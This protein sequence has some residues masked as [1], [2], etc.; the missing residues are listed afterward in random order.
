MTNRINNCDLQ[1]IHKSTSN[2]FD[3][4]M[5]GQHFRDLR[6]MLMN[7]KLEKQIDNLNLYLKQINPY[8]VS[9]N[10]LNTTRC[11]EDL[12]NLGTFCVYNIRRIDLRVYGYYFIAIYRENSKLLSELI[13][14]RSTVAGVTASG[15]F[16]PRLSTLDASVYKIFQ[17]HD[18]TSI[19]A[20]LCFY[21]PFEFIYTSSSTILLAAIDPSFSQAVKLNFD[22]TLRLYRV[23]PGVST[24]TTSFS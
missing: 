21:T 9:G 11:F 17:F 23:S 3:K 20:S 7:G 15:N 24:G 1:V 10:D 22:L 16:T 18:K 5:Q 14:Y 2:Y 6:K 13:S 19:G 4:A 8:S 12:T